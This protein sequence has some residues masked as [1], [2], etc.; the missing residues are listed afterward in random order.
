LRY[1]R[2]NAK[3]DVRTNKFLHGSCRASKYLVTDLFRVG[4]SFSEPRYLIDKFKKNRKILPSE[5][6]GNRSKVKVNFPRKL[7]FYPDNRPTH[8]ST[9]VE[10]VWFK[11]EFQIWE[12]FPKPVF[13]KKEIIEPKFSLIFQMKIRKKPRHP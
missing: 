6:Q 10:Q 4:G 7:F 9:I 1:C 5:F 8:Q 3:M 12:K 2:Y 11:N 13:Q